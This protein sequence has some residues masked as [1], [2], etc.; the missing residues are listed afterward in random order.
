MSGDGLTFGYNPGW[1]TTGAGPSQAP[2]NGAPNPAN[3][4]QFKSELNKAVSPAQ[5]S[6]QPATGW[7]APTASN[8]AFK[9]P[10]DGSLSE[11]FNNSPVKSTEQYANVRQ[12][13]LNRA[14]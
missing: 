5:T 4:D 2:T 3:T 12:S 14:G 13:I 8:F 10:V 11:G 6:A 7:G 1:G 9:A